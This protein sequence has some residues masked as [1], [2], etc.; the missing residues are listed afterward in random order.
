MKAT[1]RSIQHQGNLSIVQLSTEERA[2]ILF[3]P[4]GPAIRTGDLIITEMHEAGVVGQIRAENKTSHFLLLTDAD[5]LTGAKQTRIVNKSV[6]LAPHS[7]TLLSVSC[8]E[9]SRWNKTSDR[10]GFS[11]HSADIRMRA[12]KVE[13]SIDARRMGRPARS[14]QGRIWETVAK[15]MK[16]QQCHSITESYAD[17]ADHLTMKKPLEWPGIEP[18]PG[19]NALIILSGGLL[20]SMDTFGNEE[21]YGFYF[22]YLVQ[23]AERSLFHPEE[24]NRNK[25][26]PLESM[27][28]QAMHE[29]TNFKREPDPEYV[30]AG[31]LHLIDVKQA[32]GAELTYDGELVHG[33]VFRREQV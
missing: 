15:S 23:A 29:M 5:I 9:R 16:E 19:A 26:L 11:P 6:L 25:D 32:V 22:R 33:S 28:A 4:G 12:Q 21:A 7:Q 8:V 3:Q 24:P 31:K 18:E 10:F 1:I 27:I 14:F 2:G 13:F 30:G 20:E 17:L